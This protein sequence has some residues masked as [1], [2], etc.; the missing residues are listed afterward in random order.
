MRWVTTDA[1]IFGDILCARMAKRGVCGAR[2]RRRRARRGRRSRNGTARVSA[3]AR[4]R[5]HRSRGSRLSRGTSRSA[6][7]GVAVFPNDVVGGRRRR[8]GSDSAGVLDQVGGRCGRAGAP[9]GVDHGREVTHGAGVAGVYPPNAEN[10]AALRKDAR[11]E[12]DQRRARRLR[13]RA[14]PIPS[15][16]SHRRV[17]RSTA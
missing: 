16:R 10:L 7:A 17:V 12:V 11:N 1:G 5:R 13:H 4:P 9:R 15:R 14:D 8:R 6:A 3:R 2:D